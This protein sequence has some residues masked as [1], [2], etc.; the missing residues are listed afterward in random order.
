MNAM[1]SQER[2][3]LDLVDII[4]LKW[5]MAREGHHVH[6]ERLQRDPAYASTCLALAATSPNEA[7]QAAARRLRRCLERMRVES[8][9]QAAQEDRSE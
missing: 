5:L 7:T 4:D 2:Q 9:G 6:V 8:E 3:S 1:T